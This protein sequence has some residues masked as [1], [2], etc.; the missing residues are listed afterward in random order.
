MVIFRFVIRKSVS[1]DSWD[2][3]T[4]VLQGRLFFLFF[5]VCFQLFC[6]QQEALFLRLL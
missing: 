2:V 1:F 5:S 4:S 6:F 3:N